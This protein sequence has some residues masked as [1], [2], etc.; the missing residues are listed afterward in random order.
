MRLEDEFCGI[1][2]VCLLLLK[3]FLAVTH[4]QTVN[5]HKLRERQSIYRTVICIKVDVREQVKAKA[6]RLRCSAIKKN[7]RVTF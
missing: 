6:N 4:F 2:F 7:V 3:L 1:L 5:T